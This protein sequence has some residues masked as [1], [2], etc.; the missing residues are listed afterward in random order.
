[1]IFNTNSLS[2]ADWVKLDKE[3]ISE[4]NRIYTSPKARRGRSPEEVWACVRKGRPAEY[5]LRKTFNW[6]DDPRGYHDLLSHVGLSIEV[7]CWDEWWISRNIIQLSET[8]A[9]G[10]W[11]KS[12]WVFV[13]TCDVKNEKYTLYDIYEWNPTLETFIPGK[14]D[15]PAEYEV[16][17]SLEADRKFLEEIE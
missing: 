14:F 8:R 10:T 5:F 11:F 13:F 7:K 16:H 3:M 4:A 15:W 12:D 1:M 6:A 2:D 17:E 9:K